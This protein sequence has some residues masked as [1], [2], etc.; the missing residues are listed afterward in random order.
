MADIYSTSK[1][2]AIMAKISGKEN[3]PEILARKVLFA[4]GFRYRKND[5]RYPGK[6]DIILPR[7]KIAI[8]I[9]G[10]FWHGHTC[11]AGKNPQSRKD[12][13][14]NKVNNTIKRDLKNRLDLEYMGWQVITI[15]QC[16]LKNKETRQKT[17]DELFRQIRSK[18]I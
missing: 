13:W 15:W 7:F 1:R 3:K 9:N 18:S 11:K 14:I 8:F 12:F 17:F 10:C 2:A 5:I 6:P 4:S 16:E